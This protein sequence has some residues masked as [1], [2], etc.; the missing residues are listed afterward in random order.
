MTSPQLDIT[1]LV[2]DWVDGAANNGFVVQTGNPP[3]TTNGWAVLSSA[4]PLVERR[5]ELSVTYTTGMIERH[6]FQHG[7]TNGYTSDTMAYVQSGNNI[8]GITGAMPEP[9]AS[10]DDVTYDG[11]TGNPSVSPTSTISPTALTDFQVF[12]DGP[13]FSDVDGTASSQDA[14]ALL[15][16]DNVFG[17]GANQ[18][19]SDIPVAKAWLA[20]STGDTSDNAASN[21]HWEAHR[22]LRSWDTT[23]LH[24][25]FGSTPGLQVFDGDIAPALDDQKGM[26][27]GSQVWFDV[28][29]Y[30]EGVRNGAAD[31]GVAISSTSTADGWQIYL[32]GD[33]TPEFRPQLIV[34]SGSVSIPST[35]LAGDY[36]S[37]GVV[38]AADYVLWRSGG[39]LANEGD[40]PGVVDAGDYTFWRAHFGET[41]SSGPSGPVAVPESSVLL[42]GLFAALGF[43]FTSSR[44][45]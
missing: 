24:S 12:L 18:A 45:R 5:P 13:Q 35:G 36:N 34:L 43:V 9:D 15:R 42:L 23:S 25:D 6:T 4:H 2:Q 1:A 16:F 39:P 11:L 17:G 27:Y 29:S 44:Q 20:I 3:G 38:D 28:T 41:S 31:N 32:N 26:I 10:V 33:A 19:P 8:F 14:F 30:L 22:M 7:D 21:G 37:D 40:N